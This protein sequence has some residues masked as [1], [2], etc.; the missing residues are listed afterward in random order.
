MKNTTKK[1]LLAITGSFLSFVL[2]AGIAIL[3][4]EIVKLH[5][6]ISYA[7]ALVIGLLALFYYFKHIIFNVKGKRPER[8]AK[9]YT[10]YG[11]SYAV[12][13]I[14]VV[15]LSMYISYIISIIIVSAALWPVNFLTS[16][17]WVFKKK[18]IKKP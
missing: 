4:T 2:E 9:F 14:L 15:L 3:L 6:D 1:I 11:I 5:S 12:N 10:L 18:L 16:E 8:I 17:S 13:W 7:I